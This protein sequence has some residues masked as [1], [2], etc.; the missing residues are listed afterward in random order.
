MGWDYDEEEGQQGNGVY[1]NAKDVVNHLLLV[2]CIK[3]LEPGV[4][5]TKFK[6]DA[7]CVVVDVVDL[8]QLDE[9]GQPG[10]LGQG[11]R[12]YQN[13]LIGFMKPRAGKPAPVLAY[14][15]TEPSSMGNPAFVLLPA[16]AVDECRQRADEWRSRNQTFVPGQQAATKWEIDTPAPKVP[17]PPA[18]SSVMQMLQ[19]QAASQQAAVARI[20]ASQAAATAHHGQTKPPF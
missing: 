18:A 4:A 15:G 13:K 10:L 11:Q 5:P 19:Q 17:T 14:M 20:K 2:W 16:H 9:S 12:W 6:A 1:I 8:D 3:Y 7:D